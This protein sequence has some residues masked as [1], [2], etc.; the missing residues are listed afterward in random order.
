MATIQKVQALII[1]VVALALVYGGYRFYQW[2][3]NSIVNVG[4]RHVQGVK[5]SKKE[6]T[7]GFSDGLKYGGFGS[8][9]SSIGFLWGG[10]KGYFS[11]FFK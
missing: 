5:E 11:G 8:P 7:D 4:E 3:G 2:W 9:A 10:A 6:A 1:G